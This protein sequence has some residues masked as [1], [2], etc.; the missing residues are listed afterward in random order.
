MLLGQRTLH[1]VTLTNSGN[2]STGALNVVLPGGAPWLSL[3]GSPT[4]APLA[5]FA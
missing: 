2:A 4:L 3:Y 1:E 5:P